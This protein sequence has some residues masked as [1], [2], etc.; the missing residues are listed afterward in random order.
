MKKTV[1]Q[2]AIFFPSGYTRRSLVLKVSI[3][4]NISGLQI[5]IQTFYFSLQI[6]SY[7]L[8]KVPDRLIYLLR[9][10]E[11]RFF[12]LLFAVVLLPDVFFLLPVSAAEQFQPLP[13]G[14]CY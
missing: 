10:R 8:F 13:V 7:T 1:N 9:L 6:N 11:F 2:H 3:T 14:E 5:R 12:Q 4:G